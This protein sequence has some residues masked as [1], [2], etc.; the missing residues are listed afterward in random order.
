MRRECNLSFRSIAKAYCV[1]D[2]PPHPGPDLAMMPWRLSK[3]GYA[4]PERPRAFA[5]AE[6]QRESVRELVAME[7]PGFVAHS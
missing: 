4:L 6:R 5:E 3:A 7:R 2:L 1:T